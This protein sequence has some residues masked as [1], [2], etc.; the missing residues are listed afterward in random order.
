MTI[1]MYNIICVTSRK[2]CE[3]DF[4]ER[5]E[6]IASLHPK[7]VILREKDLTE[8]EYRELAGSVIKVCSKYDTPCILHSFV[9]TALELNADRIHLPLH[10]FR[11]LDG[12]TKSRFKL[13]GVS[14]HS[15]A[16][17]KEAESK[18]ADY[19]IAGHIFST[20]CKKGLAPRGLDFLKEVCMS[21]SIPVYAIGGISSENIKSV[22]D[23]GAD[24]A[25]IMS[26]FM[27][28]S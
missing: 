17:A 1:F 26:G 12:S 16:E 11:E 15:V 23:C 3:G 7:A 5:I 18:G 9:S 22:L 14:C 10:I 6:H 27:R 28:N 19:V 4:L 25:C 20:D 21:V 24:G 2:L 13:I 8:N